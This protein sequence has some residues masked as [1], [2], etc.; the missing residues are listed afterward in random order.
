MTDNDDRRAKPSAFMTDEL[1]P[2]ENGCSQTGRKHPRTSTVVSVA[3]DKSSAV[4]ARLAEV[5]LKYS[6]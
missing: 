4:D 2:L 6:D 1:G 5:H 3:G